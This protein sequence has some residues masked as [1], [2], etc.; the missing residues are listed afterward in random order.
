MRRDFTPPATPKTKIGLKIS[1]TFLLFILTTPVFAGAKDIPSEPAYA[2]LIRSKALTL[3]AASRKSAVLQLAR[4]HVVTLLRKSDFLPFLP[5]ERDSLG[6]LNFGSSTEDNTKGEDSFTLPGAFRPSPDYHHAGGIL[7]RRSTVLFG[8]HYSYDFGHDQAQ[9][10]F[11]PFLGQGLMRSS[12]VWGVDAS[13]VLG[14]SEKPWGLVSVRYDQGDAHLTAR[15]PGYDVQAAWILHKNLTLSLGSKARENERH[16]HYAVLRWQ[17]N[18][19]DD[20]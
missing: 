5:L 19:D 2:S 12:H 3:P 18:D 4:K 15:S 16:A 13:L 20:P 10:R 8:M 9:I 1:V 7:P 17:W 14:A 11:H 6:F